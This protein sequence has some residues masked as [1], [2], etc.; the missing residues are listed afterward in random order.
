MELIPILI[1]QDSVK[2]KSIHGTNDD[3]TSFKEAAAPKTTSR[4]HKIEESKK[5]RKDN[6]EPRLTSKTPLFN[7]DFYEVEEILDYTKQSNG[8]EK[9]LI[10]W[11][12]YSPDDDTWE[13]VSSLNKVLQ[14]EVKQIWARKAKASKQ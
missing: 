13:P 6:K 14:K 12:G 11:K 10:R 1:F 7:D 2:P 4:K 9:V 8:I 5:P 3:V